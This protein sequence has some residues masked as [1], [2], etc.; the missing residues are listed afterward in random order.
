MHMNGDSMHLG[1]YAPVDLIKRTPTSRELIQRYGRSFV[2]H[3]G[4]SG[5][6]GLSFTEARKKQRPLR[7]EW[8]VPA[9]LGVRERYRD[10][11]LPEIAP[12][13]S[14]KISTEEHALLCRPSP[15]SRDYKLMNNTMKP[16]YHQATGYKRRRN[17]KHSVGTN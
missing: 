17:R 9:S 12:T 2:I 10:T 16:R 7:I 14:N 4:R 15:A 6:A 13:T 8:V 3:E 11:A 1:A 5:H